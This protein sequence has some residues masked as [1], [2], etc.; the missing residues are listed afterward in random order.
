MAG[1]RILKPTDTSKKSTRQ[2]NGRLLGSQADGYTD[3]QAAKNTCTCAE[4][5]ATP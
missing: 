4:T 1:E 3:R 5:H 2:L